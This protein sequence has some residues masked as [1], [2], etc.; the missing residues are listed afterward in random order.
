MDQC[1][2]ACVS[3]ERAYTTIKGTH[4]S[5]EKSRRAAKF[6]IVILLIGI[7]GSCIDDP[8]HR[9]L[10]DEGNEDDN[11]RRIWCIVTYE[12]SVDN[13]QQFILNKLLKN[14]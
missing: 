4:F 6:I 8:I 10:I 5:K 2:N 7:I 1:L 13:D 14:I 11:V 3:T 9:H 12:R